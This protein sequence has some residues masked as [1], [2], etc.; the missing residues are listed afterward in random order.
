MSL[1]S[2]DSR[3][4][5]FHRCSTIPFIVQKFKTESE[6]EEGGRKRGKVQADAI[7][8]LARVRRAAE[9]GNEQVNPLV[10][11]G[12]RVCIYIASRRYYSRCVS[13]RRGR[14]KRIPA[15]FFPAAEYPYQR[16]AHRLLICGRLVALSCY[17]EARSRG[18]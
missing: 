8:R 6:R 2:P 18:R 16:V 17:Y 9:G 1:D 4:V 14:I 11:P 3:F 15:R 12:P 7:Y 5:N 10:K 13:L